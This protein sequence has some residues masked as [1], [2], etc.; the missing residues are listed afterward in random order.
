[1]TRKSASVERGRV[2]LVID[3]AGSGDAVDGAVEACIAAGTVDGVSILGSAPGAAGACRVAA[4]AGLS[5][6]AHLNAVEEP[7]LTMRPVSFARALSGGG[8]VREDIE[9]EW[10]AQIELLIS[11]GADLSRL[12][13]HRHI[14]HLPGLSGLIVNLAVE[15]GIPGVR[16][17]L[18]P[19]PLARPSGLLLRA[20]GRRLARLAG[21]A[22]LHVP[23]SMAGFGV[24]GRLDRGYLERLRIPPG[25][26]EL[27]AHPATRP[28]WSPGQ[29]SEL[30]LLT[31]DWFAGWKSA[32]C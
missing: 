7:L 6:G 5:V 23:D 21:R 11:S 29:P 24:S 25:E 3:D 17:A 9:R 8:G 2:I 30:S 12:D 26:C 31:S 15:Y 19:D 18:L 1:M 27:V 16:A 10:R 32:A 22:S 13:S 20:L 28:V 4:G 14:H